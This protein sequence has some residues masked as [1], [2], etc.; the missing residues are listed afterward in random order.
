MPPETLRGRY[1]YY[2]HYKDETDI[3]E[4]WS[5]SIYLPVLVILDLLLEGLWES[6]CTHVF[7]H[8]LNINTYK[9]NQ[10]GGGPQDGL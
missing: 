9:Y 7:F 3:M 8:P 1:F 6:K 10:S 4:P 2:P 5:M